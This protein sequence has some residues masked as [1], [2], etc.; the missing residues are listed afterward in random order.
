MSSSGDGGGGGGASNSAG[1]PPSDDASSSS[2]SCCSMTP[3][4][5]AGDIES[6]HAAAAPNAA[7]PPP[8]SKYPDGVEGPADQF[9]D[10]DEAAAAAAPTPA[11]TGGM[12][13]GPGGLDR[14]FSSSLGDGTSKVH[15]AAPGIPSGSNAGTST[16]AASLT[17]TTQSQV[18]RQHDRRQGGT[19][20][21]RPDS[22]RS[23]SLE[24]R[25]VPDHILLTARSAIMDEL[26]SQ[27]SRGLGMG[28]GVGLGP[29]PGGRKRRSSSKVLSA[30]QGWFRK[31]LLNP[32][33]TLRKQ[34]MLTFGSVSA[35]TIVVVMI[36]AVI[37]SVLT[38]NSIKAESAANV[39]GWVKQSLGTT[40][41]YV[42][43]TVSPRLMPTDLVQ[44]MYEVARDRF[45]GYPTTEDDSD[46]PFFDTI[47]QTNVYPLSNP[48]LPLDWDFRHT[49]DE[50]AGNVNEA[51][52]EEHVQ[53]RWSW[54]SANPRLSTALSLYTMQGACDPRS[55]DP[56]DMEFYPN[57]TDA[58]NDIST[59]GVI[60]PSPTNAQVARKA[61]DLSPFLKALF[62]YNQDIKE[63]GYYFGNSGAG[64]SIMFPHYEMDGRNSYTSVG[65]D[66]MRASNPIDPS[67]GPIGT[68]EEIA[69]CHPEG[70]EVPVREY[71][72]LERGWCRD[73]ALRPDRVQNIGPFRDA[74]NPDNWLMLAGRPIYDTKTGAF[75]A[76]IL[77]DFTIDG[78]NDILDAV[79]V[80]DWS[81]LSL[82][83]YDESGTVVTSPNFDLETADGT[84]TI[85]DSALETGVDSDMFQSIKS[86]VNFLQPWDADEARRLFE[87][88]LFESDDGSKFISA[89]PIPAIPDEYDPNY[90]P[91][92][93][94]IISLATDEGLEP[95]VDHVSD[96]V[97]NSVR[98]LIIFTVVLG[99]AGL[100]VIFCLIYGVSSWLTEPLKWMNNVG[101][102]V[103]GKFGED[104]DTGI[105]YERKKALP[106]SPETELSSLTRGFS[107]MVS[108]FSGEG[109]ANRV[110]V[111]EAESKNIF[112]LSNKFSVLYQSRKDAAFAYD[113]A[114]QSSA[115]ST[116]SSTS[117]EMLER[118]NFG[119][120]FASGADTASIHTPTKRQDYD[121]TV[122]KSPLFWWI[123]GL[124]VTPLLVVAVS[125]SAVVLVN[126]ST[127]LPTLI[128]PVKEEYLVLRN[129]T[130]FSA[131][132]MRAIQAAQVTEK[133]ARDNHLLTRFASWLLFDG[134][135][136]SNSFIE[137]LEG[138]EECKTSADG[139]QCSW[140]TNRLCDCAWNDIGSRTTGKCTNFESGASRPLQKL[141]FE[142]Q[143]Q[144]TDIFGTRLS[145]SFPN[146]ASSPAATSWWNNTTV[147]P[148]L[149]SDVDNSI[150]TRY[151][152]TYGRVRVLSALSSVM[153]PLY[154]YD[155]SDDKPFGMYIGYEADGMLAG[156][157]GCDYS[158]AT[159]PF[160]MS[161]ESNGAPKLRPEL[162]P[163]GKYGYDARCRG[164]YADSKSGA[165]AGEGNL[166]ITSPYVFAQA[167]LFAQSASTP[168]I[169][170]RTQTYVGQTL[171]DLIPSSIFTSLE[172]DNTKLDPGGFPILVTSKKS[173][174]GT[175][176]LVGPNFSLGNGKGK[177]I[178]ELVLPYDELYCEEEDPK[179]TAWK[180]FEPILSEMKKGNA[181]SSVFTRTG[182]SGVEEIIDI[183]YAPVIVKHFR[184]LNSSDLSRG[185]EQ[186]DILI[187]SLALAETEEGI[188]QSFQSIDHFV[189]TEVNICIAV[190][191]VLIFFSAIITIYIAYRVTLS[192]IRPILNLVIV[193]EDINR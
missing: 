66:W 45:A 56:D 30:T 67:L 50:R 175:D 94:T 153:I 6:A 51:N 139:S 99:F 116:A 90:Y 80:D 109:T 54:F 9:E 108:R 141:H 103:V 69:R 92:F 28:L 89:Y 107:K 61:A 18:R 112:N 149:H 47:S 110:K 32:Q 97:D 181:G 78:V 85:D 178:E 14:E 5:Q 111:K 156:Y 3:Q 15:S 48:P 71:N 114:R 155:T 93:L 91:E 31:V 8:Q 86:L 159:F 82:V 70:T 152:S 26:E 83:R 117:E 21:R 75:I 171:V 170:P 37:A 186:E 137:L 166:H 123:L 40:A 95:I 36:V 33:Y 2:S 60:A 129:A 151:A 84:T 53:G 161:S 169:D 138:A 190:L 128:I 177:A 4:A 187:Y 63:L 43:E 165:N 135:D 134:M 158:F 1:A 20:G 16:A 87:E 46:T 142:G 79:K 124:I 172:S 11:P 147:L 58:N 88:T 174:L 157:T 73:Q 72:P 182:P 144:D 133:S 29:G 145:T 35:L 132:S 179:C 76:C 189:K 77:V 180:E 131:T 192:M 39:E 163:L 64:S 24:L 10:E 115:V 104:L 38:G 126:I 176:T 154:N 68:E 59:G 162:C 7:A 19:T 136:M 119:P 42:A 140:M 121:G 13:T 41:R 146:V 12:M 130:R 34:M 74:W 49:P 127:E 120:N 52:Y 100:V 17:S 62:E 188:T 183:S 23:N 27:S 125:I 167:D 25:K 102:Q 122:A 113:Y 81:M 168:L 173:V 143:N 65:C 118:H 150:G 105:N 184:A 191:S 193:V 101:D 57:C 148:R 55:T 164:W 96:E 22:R 185:V 44:I 98:N 106:F 160:W